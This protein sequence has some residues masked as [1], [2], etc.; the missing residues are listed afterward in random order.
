MLAKERCAKLYQLIFLIILICSCTNKSHIKSSEVNVQVTPSDPLVQ[1]D[2]DNS[3]RLK[4]TTGI[5]AILEDS[6][7]NFWFG[8]HQEGV[9]KFD[10]EKFTYFTKEDGLSHNQVRTIMED[11]KGTIWFECGQGISSYDGQ[12]ITTLFFKDYTLKDNWK[13]GDHDLWFKGDEESGFN[14][15]EGAF[16]VYRYD[17]ISFTYLRFPLTARIG[18]RFYYAVSTPAVKGR[19]GNVW[20]GTYGAVF[21][22]DGTSFATITDET[23][24]HN[25]ETGYLHVRSLFEDSKGNLWIGN[26]GIGVLLNDGNTTINFSER[27][28]LVSESSTHN[29]GM[30][31][32]GTLEHVFSIGEDNVGNMWFGDRDTGAWK[33]DGETMKNYTM[34]DGSTVPHIWQIYKDKKEELWF[35]LA[36]GSVCKFN[37][38]SFDVIF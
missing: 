30:S 16:G 19:S 21:G 9:C 6:K 28:G 29:G 20:F 7:G 12:N 35:A 33:F 31:P 11:S 36:D 4:Y 32:P 2:F 34:K 17:G 24:W 5:R 13:K 37:G 25:E 1:P 10:G 22:F 3:L 23:L 27:Q 15:L 18:E 38:E 14:D 8:S 26:N